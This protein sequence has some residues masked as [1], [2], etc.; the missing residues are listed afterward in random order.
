MSAGW[1]FQLFVVGFLVL[2]WCAAVGML[3]CDHLD[4]MKKGKDGK[5]PI[6]H[7]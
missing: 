5:A 1:W 6:I 4:N 2:V 3:I 7:P